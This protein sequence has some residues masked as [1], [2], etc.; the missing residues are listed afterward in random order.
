MLTVVLHSVRF[1]IFLSPI[2]YFLVRLVIARFLYDSQLVKLCKLIDISTLATQMKN[3]TPKY[4]PKLQS[5]TKLYHLLKLTYPY[6]CQ[7]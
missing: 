1:F 4:T 2:E 5:N 3:L 7:S 6:A